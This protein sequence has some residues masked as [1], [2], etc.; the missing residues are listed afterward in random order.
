[1]SQR[2]DAPAAEDQ[3]DDGGPRC[4]CGC[5]TDDVSPLGTPPA[6]R[7]DGTVVEAW[8]CAVCCHDF[9]VEITEP[10]HLEQFTGRTL[11]P[12]EPAATNDTV[13]QATARHS[14]A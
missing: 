2:N 1:M 9:E 7:A 11:T 10:S 4:P 3:E 8:W 5:S 12:A 13:A 14:R 6:S